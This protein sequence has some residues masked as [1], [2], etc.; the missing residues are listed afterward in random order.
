MLA[1]GNNCAM[2]SLLIICCTKHKKAQTKLY[3]SLR[4]FP[5]HEVK[6]I[7]HE[8]NTVG[9]PEIYNQYITKKYAKKHDVVL[10]V[11]DDVYIDDFKLR[12]KLYNS[13]Q[14][15]DIVG[16]A[17]CVKPVIK[18]P[19]LW[20]LM[21]SKENWRGYVHHPRQNADGIICTSFGYTPAR[22]A[23]IDGLFIGVNIKQA[24]K[25]DWRFN[26][27]FTFHHYDIA[28]CIDANKKKLK[29]GTVPIHVIH[30]SPGLS[31]LHDLQFK[32][33]ENRFMEL[34]S[35]EQ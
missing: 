5:L 22:V 7:Y 6:C 1:A 13:I 34:Y 27:N 2:K 30:S 10:F 33:S 18:K 32:E 16:L 19:V 8:N 35:N 21:S 31:N 20:H 23:I 24:L 25:Y 4:G 28:S 9:L 12:G 3:E 17:G 15:F 14:Q 26:E 29:I 11:H